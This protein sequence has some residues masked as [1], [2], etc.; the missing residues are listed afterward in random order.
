MVI[1]GHS[2]SHVCTFRQDPVIVL[3]YH[4]M[5]KTVFILDLNLLRHLAPKYLPIFTSKIFT[6]INLP[7]GQ[8][9]NGRVLKHIAGNGPVYLR[10]KENDLA[11]EVSRATN[12]YEWA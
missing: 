6:P 9:I 7:P 1:R 2:W 3:Y 10:A 12:Q 5:I 4:V 8:E 11:V